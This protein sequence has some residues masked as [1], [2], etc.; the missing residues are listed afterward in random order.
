MR[1]KKVV[2][3]LVMI[4]CMS[5]PQIATAADET[6]MPMDLYT[7]QLIVTGDI[8][9][10]TG[11]LT[12]SVRI[13]TSEKCEIYLTSDVYRYEDGNWQF[14]KRF[15][16]PSIG[17]YVGISKLYENSCT[18]TKGYNYKIDVT[19]YVTSVEDGISE[20][21]TQSSRILSYK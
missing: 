6:I 16:N 15:R 13:T 10:I 3:L 1:L 19:A 11:E 21:I 4:L 5:L 12:S 7:K 20:E 8:D 14:V 18:V 9:I 2:M 17:T